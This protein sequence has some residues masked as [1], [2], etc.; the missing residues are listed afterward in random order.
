M[1]AFE[2][3]TKEE[4]TWIFNSMRSGEGRAGYAG[5]LKALG[6]HQGPVSEAGS[7]AQSVA[8]EYWDHAFRLN[9]SGA[10]EML[11]EYF[12]PGGES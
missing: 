7:L 11:R 4:E 5:F 9:E 2:S 10:I 1:S 6:F 3:L 12:Q 8:Y